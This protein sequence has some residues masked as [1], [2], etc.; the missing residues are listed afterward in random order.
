MTCPG[1]HSR[2]SVGLRFKPSAFPTI[3]VL[4]FQLLQD[5]Q[6]LLE[7]PTQGC[8]SAQRDVPLVPPNLSKP[9]HLLL[10]PSW[11]HWAPCLLAS[12]GKW[13]ELSGQQRSLSAAGALLGLAAVSLLPAWT[14]KLRVQ[15]LQILRGGCNSSAHRG[16]APSQMEITVGPALG[17]PRASALLLAIC[18]PPNGE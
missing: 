6:S 11:C 15:L 10:R 9:I 17:V 7:V 1:S 3:N 12:A 14:P 13:Q 5:C 8:A 16:H 2:D 4:F 18:L